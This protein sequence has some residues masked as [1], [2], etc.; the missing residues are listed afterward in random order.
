M[1]KH[2][3]I[4]TGS[5]ALI[6]AISKV[7]DAEKELQYLGKELAKELHEL[8]WTDGEGYGQLMNFVVHINNIRDTL[9]NI[10]HHTA[11]TDML[12]AI[13]S[14]KHVAVNEII[15]KIRNAG[16]NQKPSVSANPQQQEIAA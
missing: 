16:A 6:G 2:D 8:Q 14:D 11:A 3:P 9:A 7:A 10:C 4:I 1:N 5:I 12:K 13:P 15:T